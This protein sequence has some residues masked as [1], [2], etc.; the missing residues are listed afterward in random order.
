[1]NKLS[2]E[3]SLYLRQHQSNPINWLTLRDNP[4]LLAK[5]ENKPVF[6]SIGYSSCHWCHVM[7]R[8]TFENEQVANILNNNFVPVKVDR[9]EY[10]DIDKKYQ[11]YIQLLG[12]NGGWPLSVF[13]DDDGV[14]FFA[15]TYFPPEESNGMP[16]FIDILKQISN[17]YINDKD[18][19]SK[20]RESYFNIL[21]EQRKIDNYNKLNLET[22]EEGIYKILDTDRG[23]FK[24]KAKFPNIPT[25][26]ALTNK[27]FYNKKDI[28]DFLNLTALKLCT[29]GIFDHIRGGFFRYCVDEKWEVPHFEKMLYDNA[30]NVSFLSKMFSLTN[31]KIHLHTAE[32]TLD[33]LM[34]EFFTEHG[35]ISSMN[36]ESEDFVGNKSEG[37]Y[38]K[39]T[40]NDLK[41]LDDFEAKIISENVFFKDNVINLQTNSYKDILKTHTILSKLNKNKKLPDKD[42]K[43]I[44]SWNSL[45]VIAMLDYFEVSADDFYYNTAL[46][47]FGKLKQHFDGENLYRI[48]YND[49]LFQHSC[50]EDYSYLIAAAQKVFEITKESKIK[51][52]AK[53]LIDSAN[54]LFFKDGLLYFDKDHS[55]F[56]TFDD[57]IYSAFALFVA[58]AV[59]FSKFIDLDVDIDVLRKISLDRFNKF[60]LAHP[61]ILK[62][63][64]SS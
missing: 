3:P 29:S 7:S 18:K 50:L 55:V 54:R 34:E 12:K 6:L 13:T 59:Y 38:Y 51:L 33:F 25:M 62:Y 47:L 23:G 39:V 22:F 44:V 36:A 45:L 37:F 60:P 42:Y 58:G 63:I 43:I 26:I 11:F 31:S 41:C 49:M 8:E 14:P 32:I 30:L 19:L 40:E 27:H 5:N 46:N 52:F 17:F 35:F 61:T 53:Q 24:G 21:R 64:K 10:P 28:Q 15:G 20:I 16:G 4:F 1:M 2:K 57:A 48:R 56:D 9:E